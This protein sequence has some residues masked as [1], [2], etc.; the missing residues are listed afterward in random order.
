MH[1]NIYRSY[2]ENILIG[3]LKAGNELAYTEIYDRYIFSMLEHAYNKCRSKEVAKDVVQ[4]VFT[5]LWTR[6][7]SFDEN[8]NLAG[9]LYTATR[10]I[11]INQI[12][13]NGIHARFMASVQ[14]FE[15]SGQLITDALVRENQMRSIIEKEIFAL[16]PKMRTIFELSRKEHLS[17]KAIAEKLGLSESTVSRQIS[18]ALKILKVKLGI[19]TYLLFLMSN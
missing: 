9:Y 12:N 4:E 8:Q 18:N 2:P 1:L 5:M 14:D 15:T 19:V 10:N 16:P 11:I 7:E 3:L 13:R 17:H 6:R